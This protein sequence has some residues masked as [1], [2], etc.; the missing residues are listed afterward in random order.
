MGK[1][2]I[3]S[4]LILVDIQNDFCPGGALAVQEGDEVVEVVNRLMLVF[5]FVVA[6]QDWHPPDHISFKEQGGIWPPH[7]VQNT[8]GAELHPKLNQKA[9]DLYFRKAFKANHDSLVEKEKKV[10]RQNID[11]EL[12]FDIKMSRDLNK[13][14][15][16]AEQE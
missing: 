10:E 7:C 15:D 2:F 1:E 3:H 11:P 5:P 16:K 6:T 9:I 4:A 14:N 13:G 8:Y 12:E